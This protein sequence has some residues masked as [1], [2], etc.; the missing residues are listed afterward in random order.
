MISLA[1]IGIACHIHFS[2]VCVDSV[3]WTA[4][5]CSEALKN[6]L[7]QVPSTANGSDASPEPRQGHR[8]FAAEEDRIVCQAVLEAGPRP[9]SRPPRAA[10]L[11]RPGQWPLTAEQERAWTDA[12][13]RLL[14]QKAQEV[15]SH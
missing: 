14:V 5:H 3:S 2:T 9:G 7:S 12:G 4:L 13:D 15:G 11:G 10:V 1:V 8:F 6:W